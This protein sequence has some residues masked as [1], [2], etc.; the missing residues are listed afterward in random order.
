MFGIACGRVLNRCNN[1]RRPMS[2]KCKT[3]RLP[4]P[5]IRLRPT[6]LI[7]EAQSAPRLTDPRAA[8]KANLKFIATVPQCDGV[9]PSAASRSVELR[10]RAHPWPM[11]LRR[12]LQRWWQRLWMDEMTAYFSEATSHADLE[13]RIRAWDDNQRR[14]HVPF[15]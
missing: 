7:R 1:A 5:S 11:R 14:G 13:H 2:Q 6:R 9:A 3:P 4:A 12:A 15:V 8:M 10:L